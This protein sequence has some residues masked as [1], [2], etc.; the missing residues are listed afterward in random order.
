[1]N[2]LFIAHRGNL[3][4]RVPDS[5]NSPSYIDYAL[6]KGYEVEVDVWVDGGVVFLGHDKPEYRCST[7]WLEERSSR[8]WVHCKNSPAIE[9]IS[10]TSLNWFVHENDPYTLT[11]QGF[12]WGYPGVEPV[13]DRFILLWFG[14][15]KPS[16]A[17]AG[18]L[19][20]AYCGDFIESWRLS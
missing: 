8:L 14:P 19:P 6:E 2:P 3:A 7:S 18:L 10:S 16:V 12:I 11:S 15:E 1:V 4:G 13:G 17:K 5:E 9:V 20:Y